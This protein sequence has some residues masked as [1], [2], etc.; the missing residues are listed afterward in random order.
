MIRIFYKSSLTSSEGWSQDIKDPILDFSRVFIQ[1]PWR[2]PAHVI[3]IQVKMPIVTGADIML[4]VFMPGYAASQVC[5]DIGKYPD[6]CFV[7]S[8]SKHTVADACPFPA[9]DAGSCEFEWCWNPN[10]NVFQSP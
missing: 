3:S 2:R 5:A 4:Q 9:I 8:D 6:I 1:R 7:L 10:G